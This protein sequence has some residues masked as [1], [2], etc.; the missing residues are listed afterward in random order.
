MHVV[1]LLA[2]G[3]KTAWQETKTV[4]KLIVAAKKGRPP[5]APPLQQPFITEQTAE[6]EDGNARQ[7]QRLAEA[8]KRPLAS[9]SQNA[10]REAL[11]HH[12]QR[13]PLCLRR[14]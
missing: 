9:N 5:F 13:S 4:E 11:S 3:P 2:S 1:F 12:H 7:R 10:S 8:R 6:E 14:R